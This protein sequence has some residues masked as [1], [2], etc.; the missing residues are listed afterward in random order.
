MPIFY[1]INYYY[2][3]RTKYTKIQ[4][5]KHVIKITKIKA[6]KNS[7]HQAELQLKSI[8]PRKRVHSWTKVNKLA[9]EIQ[10]LDQI[11]TD[12]IVLKINM[13]KTD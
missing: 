10:Q 4:K 2:Y 6:I 5:N 11:S 9:F 3:K 7:G 1:I 13:C 8:N 12:I